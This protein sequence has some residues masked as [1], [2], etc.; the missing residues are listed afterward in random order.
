MGSGAVIRRDTLREVGEL[1]PRTND[2]FRMRLRG[3]TDAMPA[4]VASPDDAIS[5][6]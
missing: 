1:E 6:I 3:L 2:R 4:A 5:A